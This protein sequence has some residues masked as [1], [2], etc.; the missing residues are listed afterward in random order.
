MERVRVLQGCSILEGG[1]WFHQGAVL[2]VADPSK[3]YRTLT[4]GEGKV[5]ILPCTEPAE[6]VVL[7][8]TE[9]PRKASETPKEA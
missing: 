6:P 3:H 7:K 8:P 4:D 5:T 1:V 2:D 9:K